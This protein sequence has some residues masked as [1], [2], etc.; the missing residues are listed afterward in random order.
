VA[1]Q[2]IATATEVNTATLVTRTKTLSS[3]SSITVHAATVASPIALDLNGDG[4]RTVRLANAGNA[5]FDLLNTGTSVRSGWLDANDAFLTRDLNGNGRIDDR[6]ELFGGAF[7]EGFSL[8][9]S[10]DSNQDGRIDRADEAFASLSLWQ[11]KDSNKQTDE[12][13]LTS[14]MQSG[15]A[16]ISLAYSLNAQWQEGNLLLEQS[17]AM[18][19][20]GSRLEVRDAYFE[21]QATLQPPS[22]VLESNKSVRI[23]PNILAKFGEE[24]SPSLTNAFF[25]RDDEVATLPWPIRAIN[26]GL[27][28]A[29]K[30]VIQWS[31][32]TFTNGFNRSTNVADTVAG[33]TNSGSTSVEELEPPSKETMPNRWL[34]AFLKRFSLKR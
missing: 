21:V 2:I 31:T 1:L 10:L 22:R 17:E 23:P 20:D 9:S 32:P 11:D 14:L 24:N 15:I 3:S 6:S 26:T 7:G 13:E 8:L 28:Q 33:D 5:K 18:R 4:V 16:S 27:S 12:G 30:P 25:R 19:T 34:S 29:T